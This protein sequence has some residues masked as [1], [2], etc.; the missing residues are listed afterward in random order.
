[1]ESSERRSREVD[2]DPRSSDEISPLAFDDKK[3]K[4]KK[5]KGSKTKSKDG[6]KK[7]TKKS[8]KK[9]KQS[10]SEPPEDM[11]DQQKRSDGLDRSHQFAVD[12][13]G[14]DFALSQSQDDQAQI[15]KHSNPRPTTD[16]G[17]NARHPVH[18]LSHLVDTGGPQF[19]RI[20]PTENELDMAHNP[21]VVSRNQASNDVEDEQSV[22]GWVID[23]T[24][25]GEKIVTYNRRRSSVESNQSHSPRE[26][27]VEV[28]TTLIEHNHC[29]EDQRGS[30]HSGYRSSHQAPYTSGYMG[31]YHSQYGDER[32][33]RSGGSSFADIPPKGTGSGYQGSPRQGDSYYLKEHVA[34]FERDQGDEQLKYDDAYYEEYAPDRLGDVIGEDSFYDSGTIRSDI[35]GLTGAF[36]SMYNSRYVHNRNECIYEPDV[37]PL[38]YPK[39]NSGTYGKFE[40]MEV[41]ERKKRRQEHGPPAGVR[42]GLIDIRHYERVLGDNPRYVI[43]MMLE[44]GFHSFPYSVFM[45]RQLHFRCIDFHWLEVQGAKMYHIR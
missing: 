21:R 40:M 4:K 3:K 29:I 9:S 8:K 39:Y 36:S 37:L 30:E 28:N 26:A 7:K 45:V 35:T 38:G 1:M 24:N 14:A 10:P 2:T 13:T 20:I 34:S 12:F 6:D 23:D 11:W 5:D 42:F 41:L 22:G 19:S 25:R 18:P 43:A 17:L 32:S 33:R 16:P 15:L 27:K 31:E 44:G